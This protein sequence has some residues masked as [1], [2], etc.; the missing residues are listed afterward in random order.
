MFKKIIPII[1]A[2]IV[3]LSVVGMFLYFHLN[4]EEVITTTDNNYDYHTII[5][6][7]ETYHYN[8]DVISVLLLGIDSKENVDGQSDHISLLIID[9]ENKDLKLLAIPRDTITEIDVYSEE[10]E[11]LGVTDNFL[12]LAYPNGNNA[13]KGAISALK[14]TSKLLYNIPIIYYAVGNMN[15]LPTLPE[16]VGNHDVVLPDDSLSYINEEWTKG[17]V[18]NVNKDTIETYLRARDVREDFTNKNRMLRQNLYL[19]WFFDNIKNVNEKDNSFLLDRISEILED[20]DTNISL[21]EAETF[22]EIAI[23]SMRSDPFVYSLQGRYARGQ[24]FDE[25]YPNE[26]E[27]ESLIIKLFYVKEF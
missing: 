11:Y 5:Y 12:G 18:Y 6:K 4:E 3:L 7:G 25:F 15:I 21:S 26:D 23:G 9:R 19:E 16:I 1:I 14:A 27:L 22:Y 13:G 20:C 17:Y 24:F 8:T 2:V 10:G